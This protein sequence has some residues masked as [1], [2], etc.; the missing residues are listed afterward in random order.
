MAKFSS[1][2]Y[3]KFISD[4]SGQQF[5]YVERIKEWNG[6]IVHISEYEIKQPQL[7]PVK[8]PS[9]PQSLYQA[10]PARREPLTVFVGEAT[11]PPWESSPIQG[12]GAVGV[13]VITTS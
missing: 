12:I 1:G 4:R 5:P 7:D 11:F 3:A 9:E 2:K 6:S 10:R 8:V 13:V